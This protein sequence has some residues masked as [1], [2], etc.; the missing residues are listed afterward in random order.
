MIGG[1]SDN[2]GLSDIEPGGMSDNSDLS[3]IEPGLNQTNRSDDL[4]TRIATAIAQADGDLPGMEPDSCDYEMAD[5]VIAEL[6]ADYILV[7]K[8]RIR[9]AEKLGLTGDGE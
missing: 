7:P 9:S 3:D 6:E 5:A 8:G 4:R 2:G 1:M